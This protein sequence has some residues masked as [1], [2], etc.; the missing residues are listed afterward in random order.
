MPYKCQRIQKVSQSKVQ[1]IFG[2]RVI[3]CAILMFS[4]PYPHDRVFQCSN[5]KYCFRNLRKEKNPNKTVCF[6]SLYSY[7][8]CLSS[9]NS[10]ET[11]NYVIIQQLALLDICDPN[12][13]TVGHRKK[14]HFI[15]HIYCRIS[16][17][18]CHYRKWN[19]GKD[20]CMSLLKFTH[21]Y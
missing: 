17:K 16:V 10:T 20:I 19:N 3:S 21:A 12:E 4:I 6:C 8:S 15:V 9:N 18:E 7:L 1:R 5:F 2:L 13:S 11:K 14:S